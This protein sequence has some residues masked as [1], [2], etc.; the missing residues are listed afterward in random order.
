MFGSWYTEPV[1][2]RVHGRLKST[3]FDGALKQIACFEDLLI[4]D[5]TLI[6]KLWFHISK[7]A[8]HAR[9]KSLRKDPE[10]HWR[11][12]PSDWAHRELY[13]KFVKASERALRQTDTDLSPWHLI[14]ATDNRYRDSTAA[15]TILDSILARLRRIQ[16]SPTKLE[17]A[18]P[19]RIQIT[20]VNKEKTILDRVKLTCSLSEREYEK[21]LLKYQA[22]LNEL[23]WAA[24]D[25]K[26]ATV[27]VFEG[28]DAAGK[29]SCIRR[30]SAAIDPRLFRVVPIAAPNDEER[31]YHYLWR[32]WRRL[33][34]NGRATIF[35]RSWYGRVLVERV[36][37]YARPEEWARAYREINDFEEQISDHGGVLAKFWIHISADEQ[38]RRFKEREVVPFKKYKI[39]PEDWRNRGKWD[40]YKAAVN[41]MVEHTSTEYAPWTLVAGNDK[42]Y[43][44]IQILKTLCGALEDAL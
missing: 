43:A 23:T 10:T 7:K 20:P 36:E 3:E 35:D 19:R 1:I 6:I 14:E 15:R 32:F 41:D 11:V 28:W 4:R 39:T 26:I 17:G 25:R 21:K 9:L 29:G 2:G 40:H 44:R 31:S 13:G 33:P 8:L 24:H 34:A 37:G 12:L 38:L 18:L 27:I 22:N 30:V 16:R 5:G 42:R